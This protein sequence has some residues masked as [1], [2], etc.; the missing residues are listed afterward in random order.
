M[1]L[2]PIDGAVHLE[3]EP[4]VQGTCTRSSTTTQ[5]QRIA[6]NPQREFEE[7]LSSATHVLVLGHSLHDR[8]AALEA[9][10]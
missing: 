4:V 5:D 7:A 3:P 6:D 1:H 10:F 9:T 8:A 2:Y